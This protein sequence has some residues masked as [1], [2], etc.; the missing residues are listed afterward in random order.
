MIE[1][2]QVKAAHSSRRWTAGLLV[3]C[4]QVFLRYYHVEL[5]NVKVAEFAL[6][7]TVCQKYIRSFIARRN[8]EQM[9]RAA[10]KCEEQVLAL[11]L[12]VRTVSESS[13]EKQRKMRKH[14]KSIK[15]LQ[16]N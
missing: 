15:E 2:L 5:L 12:C 11:A 4:F 10:K 13:C 14:D 8:Y 16:V 3:L 9:R 7:V 6:V 1:L